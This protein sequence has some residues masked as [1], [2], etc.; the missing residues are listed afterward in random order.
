M[1]EVSPTL[2][3]VDFGSA[4]PLSPPR[5]ARVSPSL[6][7][8]FALFILIVCVCMSVLVAVALSRGPLRDS[9]P[10]FRGTLRA[11]TS[12]GLDDV[13]FASKLAWDLVGYPLYVFF[14]VG[15][16]MRVFAR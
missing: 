6:S 7:R 3:D 4:S 12:L 9:L 13:G 15:L 16:L 14:Y 1:D 8:A 11:S 5:H 2:D 10:S